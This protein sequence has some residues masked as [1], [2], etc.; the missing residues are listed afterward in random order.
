MECGLSWFQHNVNEVK[1]RGMISFLCILAQTP[2]PCPLAAY[3]GWL[4]HPWLLGERQGEA[5]QRST[6]KQLKN[7]K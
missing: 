6:S 5:E 3:K 1:V 7:L 4:T 2:T